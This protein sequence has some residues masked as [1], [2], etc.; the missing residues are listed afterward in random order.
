MIIIFTVMYNAPF[1]IL[2]R[3]EIAL[4]QNRC[5]IHQVSYIQ[6]LK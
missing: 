2:S 1:G 4:A 6:R 5:D 3:I